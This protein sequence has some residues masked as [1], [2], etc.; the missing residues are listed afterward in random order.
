MRQREDVA[1]AAVGLAARLFFDLAHELGH[2]VA[3]LVLGLLEQHVLGLRGAE[4]GDTLELDHGFVVSVLQVV[5]DALRVGVAVAQRLLAP[6]LL[7]GARVELLVALQQALLG[8]ADLFAAAAQLGLDLA[9]HLVHFLFGLEPSFLD[10]GL[11]LT[12][13]VAQHLLGLALRPGQ[14]SRGEVAADQ[15]SR[16]PRPLPGPPRCTRHS[17][18]QSYPFTGHAARK[19]PGN[20]PGQCHTRPCQRYRSAAVSAP[21]GRDNDQVVKPPKTL[22]V[23]PWFDGFS[24]WA[25]KRLAYRYTRARVKYTRHAHTSRKRIV[26]DWR[27]ESQFAGAPGESRR[28]VHRRSA[29]RRGAVSRSAS[30]HRPSRGARAL[31]C[32][33]GRRPGR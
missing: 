16:R 13:G 15:V 9:A 10:D 29:S 32:R 28:A 14:L 6:V 19:K 5:G 23:D 30:C 3:G 17:S 4:P 18:S 33:W 24:Q 25:P 12:L 27:S 1:G 20:A 11:G 22:T 31:P 2:V 8:L 7:G 26:G 21:R